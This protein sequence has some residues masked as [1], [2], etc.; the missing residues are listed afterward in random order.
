MG[1]VSVA[2]VIVGLT[3]ASDYY[4]ASIGYTT[5]L[6][7][8]REERHSID[9]STNVR[10]VIQPESSILEDPPQSADG[11]L[12]LRMRTASFLELIQVDH[13]ARS[14]W[15]AL[16]GTVGGWIGILIGV[17]FGSFCDDVKDILQRICG[18]QKE[19]LRSVCCNTW[20]TI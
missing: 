8:R 3:Q 15:W 17:S 1:N 6:S 2:S 4:V 18:K 16:I 19:S 12:E 11:R 7:F 10:T 20:S 14:T 5:M 9:G 13:R